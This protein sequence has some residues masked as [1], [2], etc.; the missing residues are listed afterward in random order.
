MRSPAFVYDLHISFYK[1][2][3]VKTLALQILIHILFVSE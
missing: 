2:V 3:K 1:I